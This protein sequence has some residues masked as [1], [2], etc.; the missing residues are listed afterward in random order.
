MNA[1]HKPQLCKEFGQLDDVHAFYNIYAKDAGFSVRIG[2][3]KKCKDTNEVER[4]EYL[5]Y[6]EGVSYT[7]ELKERKRR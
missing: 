6:K 3:S 1:D 7:A 5:C 2:S 4:K